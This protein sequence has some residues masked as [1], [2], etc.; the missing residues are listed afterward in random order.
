MS[1]QEFREGFKIGRYINRDRHFGRLSTAYSTELQDV[2]KKRIIQEQYPGRITNSVL[3]GV[4]VGDNIW[5]FAVF[6]I[7]LAVFV[8]WLIYLAIT[9]GQI[10]IAK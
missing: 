7:L 2:V 3:W 8:I 4:R 5:Y 6:A 1:W 9:T 10:H